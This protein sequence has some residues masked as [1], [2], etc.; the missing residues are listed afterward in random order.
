MRR[1]MPNTFAGRRGRVLQLGPGHPAHQVVVDA[2]DDAVRR[3]ARERGLVPRHHP[4][5]EDLLGP[6]D[7]PAGG[8][9]Q[10]DGQVRDA[11]RRDVGGY[12]KLAA[13]DDA[14]VDHA[15]RAAA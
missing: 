12:V 13:P 9:V 7:R 15:G 5:G 3:A 14:E 6:P 10:L 8:S 4:A 2:L 1:I 11:P